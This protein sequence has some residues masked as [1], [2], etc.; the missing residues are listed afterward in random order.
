[1][2][3]GL[4]R[5]GAVVWSVV[6]LRVLWLLVGVAFRLRASGRRHGEGLEVNG[7]C[8]GHLQFATLRYLLAAR[9]RHLQALSLGV[10]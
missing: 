9:E 4:G 3:A 10:R 6:G 1:M 7:G 2:L 5:L 8:T